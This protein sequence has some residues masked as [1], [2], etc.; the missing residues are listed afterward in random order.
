V[1]IAC[2]SW[3]ADDCQ[4]ACCLDRVA[5]VVLRSLTALKYEFFARK[6]SLEW[7]IAFA[8]QLGSNKQVLDFGNVSILL[9]HFN[10][11]CPMHLSLHD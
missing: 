4:F 9:A 2:L 1:F 7:A 6:K 10:L 11:V 8:D 3:F 5:S